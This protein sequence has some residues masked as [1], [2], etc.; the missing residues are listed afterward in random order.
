MVHRLLPVCLECMVVF[1][2]CGVLLL[3]KTVFGEIV[4]GF[5]CSSWISLV[6]RFLQGRRLWSG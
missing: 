4:V 1:R 3:L 6:D 5:V 2:R